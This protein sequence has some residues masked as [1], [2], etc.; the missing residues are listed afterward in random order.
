MTRCTYGITSS[1]HHSI[2]SLTSCADG[3]NVPQPV[4]HAIWSN[5]H[6]DDFLTGANCVS[7]VKALQTGFIAALKQSEFDLHKWTSNT[8]AIILDLSEEYRHTNDTQDFLANDHTIKTLGIVWNPSSDTFLI[9][10]SHIDDTLFSDKQI[11]KRQKPSDISRIFDPLGWLSLKTIVLKQLM[12]Q[13]WK[14]NI[15]W[16]EKLPHDLISIYFSW[17]SQLVSLREIKLNEVSLTMVFLTKYSYM[18]SVT[19]LK[20]RVQPVCTLLLQIFMAGGLFHYLQQK[21][22][23]LLWKRWVYQGQN[24]ALLYLALAYSSRF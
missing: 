10:T 12:Q 4:Q 24:C 16:E 21:L 5:F 22:K 8:P 11:T 15:D 13:P 3:E 20:R 23:L 18:F 9:K 14:T 17:P 1:S 7:E 2:K 6:L 19:L